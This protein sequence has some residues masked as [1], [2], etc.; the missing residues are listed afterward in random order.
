MNIQRKKSYGKLLFIIANILLFVLFAGIG[1]TGFGELFLASVDLTSPASLLT[2][3][4]F[5]II[6]FVIA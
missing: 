2:L 5:E 4:L 1:I 3:L 6:I